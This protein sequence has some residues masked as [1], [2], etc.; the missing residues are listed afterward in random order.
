[1]SLTWILQI[2][3]LSLQ[4][5]SNIPVGTS[6]LPLSF[7]YISGNSAVA[8][9]T[10]SICI[11]STS[12]IF[13][14]SFQFC[15]W[16]LFVYCVSIASSCNYIDALLNDGARPL[17]HIRCGTYRHTRIQSGIFPFWIL[18]WSCFLFFFFLFLLLCTCV[19]SSLCTAIPL[20]VVAVVVGFVVVVIA[21]CLST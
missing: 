20:I 4:W 9:C 12:I 16:Y 5:G 17:T 19:Y 13:F 3:H 14:C 7:G 21:S 6:R 15:T 2:S 11:C 10:I 18:A 1:M 8:V